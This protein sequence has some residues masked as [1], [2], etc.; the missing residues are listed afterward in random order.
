M[1]SCGVE[2]LPQAPA[3]A[4]GISMVIVRGSS[5]IEKPVLAYT[6]NGQNCRIREPELQKIMKVAHCVPA[7]S[8]H[9]HCPYWDNRLCTGH[10]IRGLILHADRK[11]KYENLRQVVG[12]H[13]GTLT[14]GVGNEKLINE[15]R[16]SDCTV[17][18]FLL[19][20]HS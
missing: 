4:T 19:W 9:S 13:S 18:L 17:V 3:L 16:K 12:K 10:P 5:C 7:A 14:Q 8:V 15:K 1:L 2:Q 20:A 11:F 6:S